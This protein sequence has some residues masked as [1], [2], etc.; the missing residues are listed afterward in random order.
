LKNFGLAVHKKNQ[1][2]A[3]KRNPKRKMM[4]K[5]TQQSSRNSGIRRSLAQGRNQIKKRIYQKYIAS[6]VENMVTTG[7]SVE[8]MVTKGRKHT[9][10]RLLKKRNP[11]RK[12]SRMK[13][14]SSTS[15]GNNILV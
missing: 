7:T 11:Q 14:P 6:T 12:S 15:H 10:Q 13:Q 1:G 5:P 8:N 3:Q 9:K 4:I 2:L